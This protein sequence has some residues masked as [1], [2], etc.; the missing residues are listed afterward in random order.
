MLFAILRWR[1]AMP[2][3]ESPAAAAWPPGTR[4]EEEQQP[5]TDHAPRRSWTVRLSAAIAL[6]AVVRVALLFTLHA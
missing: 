2:I 4:D 3:V 1:E 6:T 5:E